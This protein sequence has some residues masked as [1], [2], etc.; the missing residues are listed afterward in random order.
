MVTRFL[1]YLAQRGAKFCDARLGHPFSLVCGARST[2]NI[3]LLQPW[4]A[5]RG[6]KF[7]TARLGQPF[8]L[9]AGVRSAEKMLLL[10]L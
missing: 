7:G 10:Q 6:A 1:L 3:L 5:Q 9:V 8:S 4:R 2:E